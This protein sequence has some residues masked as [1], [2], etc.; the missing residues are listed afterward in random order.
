MRNNNFNNL[1]TKICTKHIK[2]WKTKT[3]TISFTYVVQ[4]LWLTYR[5]DSRKNPRLTSRA[6]G[7]SC[8]RR[9]LLLADPIC[10]SLNVSSRIT[11]KLRDLLKLHDSLPKMSSRAFAA[12]VVALVV[13]LPFALLATVVVV[14][15]DPT[16]VGVAAEGSKLSL[17]GSTEKEE[18]TGKNVKYCIIQFIFF[19][20]SIMTPLN[21]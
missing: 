20:T 7:I 12:A 2:N 17:I 6:R 21:N 15:F 19:I 3:C 10:R 4:C 9:R 5:G 11:A 14:S 13:A 8:D 16:A 18:S 1:S